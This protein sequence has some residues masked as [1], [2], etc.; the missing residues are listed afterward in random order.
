MHVAEEFEFRFGSGSQFPFDDYHTTTRA[1]EKLKTE[2]LNLPSSPHQLIA[3]AARH[4][5][6][7]GLCFYIFFIVCVHARQLLNNAYHLEH[8]GR[9]QLNIL[10]VP[11]IWPPFRTPVDSWAFKVG[12][13][14]FF[15]FVLIFSLVTL[16]EGK[17]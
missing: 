12:N 3:A 2:K 8:K 16:A 4:L 14:F 7:L 13:S 17:M 9:G 10:F 5:K 6:I 15:D 11:S 1:T